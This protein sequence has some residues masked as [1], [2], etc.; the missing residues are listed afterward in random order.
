MLTPLTRRVTLALALC[1]LAS[2]CVFGHRR[3]DTTST[4]SQRGDALVVVRNHHFND[5][6]VYAIVGGERVRLGN[7]TGET[8]RTLKLPAWSMSS[9]SV[10]LIADPIG[11]TG[12]A[13]SGSIPVAGGSVVTFTIEQNLALSAATVR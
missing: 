1:T 5:M 6:D 11:G 10:T 8:T 4:A 2:S 12:V 3:G 7:V 13:T 9:G